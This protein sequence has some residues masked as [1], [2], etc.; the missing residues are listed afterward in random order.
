MHIFIPQ[1]S[2]RRDEWKIYFERESKATGLIR[3]VKHLEET[4]CIIFDSKCDYFEYSR[5]RRYDLVNVRPRVIVDD[6]ANLL[7]Y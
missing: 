1:S 2:R 4:H 3:Q 7:E 5:W 6:V